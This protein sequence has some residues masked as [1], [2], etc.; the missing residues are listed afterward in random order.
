MVRVGNFKSHI[1]LPRKLRNL[2]P[3]GAKIEE[4]YIKIRLA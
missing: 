3:K 4:G 2:D 1:M